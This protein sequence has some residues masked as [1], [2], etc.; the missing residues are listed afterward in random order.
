MRTAT[1]IIRVMLL[2]TRK[3]RKYEIRYI[4]NMMIRDTKKRNIVV[5]CCMNNNLLFNYFQD[6]TI[7]V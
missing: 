2:P 4:R 7:G 5:K 1:S 6:Y 3:E